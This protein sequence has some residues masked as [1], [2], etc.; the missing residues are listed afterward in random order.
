MSKHLTFYCIG[1]SYLKA[2]A[3]TRGKFSLN[4]VTKNTVLLQAKE[5][6]L[7][8]VLVISTCNRTEIYGYANHPFELIKLL[9]D[10]SLGT[11]DDFQK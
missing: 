8:G 4:T 3:E 1:L 2:D 6:N 9:C 11:I 7:Q 10:N 5:K